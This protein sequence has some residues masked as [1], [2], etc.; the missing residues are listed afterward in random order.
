MRFLATVFSIR[1]VVDAHLTVN[2]D[3]IKVE[4]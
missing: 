3:K 4:K 1:S 2:K